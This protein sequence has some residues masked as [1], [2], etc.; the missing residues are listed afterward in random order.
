MIRCL[1]PRGMSLICQQEADP[2]HPP[3][4]GL[5]VNLRLNFHD[6]T[7]CEAF[8]FPNTQSAV[9]SLG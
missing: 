6:T 7:S 2:R 8:Q 4:G 1:G 9:L 5:L 3:V